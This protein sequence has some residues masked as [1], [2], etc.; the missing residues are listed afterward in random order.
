MP[1]RLTRTAE[2]LIDA[3][4][5]E[6]ATAYGIEAAGRY[7]RLIVA[8]LTAIGEAPERPGSTPVPRLENIRA[9]PIRLSRTSVAPQHRV[10][11]P[12]HLIIYLVAAEGAAEILG[13]VHDRMVLSRAARRLVRIADPE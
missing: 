2:E 8:A 13:L 12:R 10:R 3:V 11:T 6:S 5:L 1:Y 7:A 4:L 9:Y